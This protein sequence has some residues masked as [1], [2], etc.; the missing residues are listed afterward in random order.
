MGT[1]MTGKSAVVTGGGGGIGAAIG[2]Y[3]AT[4]IPG[5]VLRLFFILYILGVIADCLLRK[6]FMD[7]S[8]G[9][10]FHKMGRVVEFLARRLSGANTADATYA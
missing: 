2:A 7:D 3:V 6:G 1:R 10:E 8:S 5:S 9:H 4:I